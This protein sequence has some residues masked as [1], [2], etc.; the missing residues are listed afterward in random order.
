MVRLHIANT[1]SDLIQG[2]VQEHLPLERI[3]LGGDVLGLGTTSGWDNGELTFLCDDPALSGIL[4]TA[5]A[6]PGAA[7]SAADPAIRPPISS[8]VYKSEPHNGGIRHLQSGSGLQHFPYVCFSGDATTLRRPVP[9]AL[10][11]AA[12]GRPLQTVVAEAIAALR[13]DGSLEEAPIYGLRLLSRWQS[14]VIT[15][16]SKLCLGQ[17]RRN[18][19][20]ARLQSLGTGSEGVGA[21][22]YERLPHFRL[23][24]SDP[25][26]PADP[27]RWLSDSL[28]WEGCGFYDTA[29]E[30]GR[31]TVPVAGAHLHLHGCSTDLRHGGHLHHEHAGTTLTA[32]DWLVLYPLQ[33]IRTLGSDLAVRDLRWQEG[34]AQF[35]VLNQGSLDA[36]DVGVAVVLNDRY[37]G[38]RYLR[39][40]WLASGE[41]ERVTMPLPLGPGRQRLEVIVDPE[42]HILEE[43]SQ[44]GNNRLVLEIEA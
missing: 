23:S 37:S 28:R 32:I 31:V 10:L 41:A 7:D 6:P 26:D 39:L 34:E 14:L 19:G 18:E 40:P 13:A 25:A 36:S 8:R 5:A 44:R 43:E 27:I 2:D 16:A 1:V 3:P 17:M 11:A 38:H 12:A 4:A 42:H 33:H 22:I 15:V 35:T 29:P 30:L 20:L 9:A 21:S 24:A